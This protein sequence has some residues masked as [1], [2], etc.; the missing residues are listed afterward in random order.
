MTVLRSYLEIRL[1][2]ATKSSI[3]LEEHVIAKRGDGWTWQQIADN[4]HDLTGVAVSRE[5]LR[6]WFPDL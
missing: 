5:T 1:A 4:L 2:E 6:L 3:K